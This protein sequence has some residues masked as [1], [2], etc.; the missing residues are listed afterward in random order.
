LPSHY[1]LNR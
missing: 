1:I